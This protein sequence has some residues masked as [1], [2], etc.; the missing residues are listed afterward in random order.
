MSLE[1]DQLLK[2][3]NVE[4][5]HTDD[6]EIAKKIALDHLQEDPIYYDKLELIDPHENIT[7]T[8]PDPRGDGPVEES[9]LRQKLNGP[10]HHHRRRRGSHQPRSAARARR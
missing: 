4:M 10:L 7:I 5:E 2:G 6:R 1:M 3:I 8:P 9:W